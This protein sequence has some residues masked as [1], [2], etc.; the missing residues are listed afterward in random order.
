MP[1]NASNVTKNTPKMPISR[2]GGLGDLTGG[3]NGQQGSDRRPVRAA[4]PDPPVSSAFDLTG[5]DDEQQGT[6]GTRQGMPFRM[7]VTD[8][9][10]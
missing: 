6:D 5:E 8:R 7:R 10:N 4:Q 2:A 3:D 1:G 9:V